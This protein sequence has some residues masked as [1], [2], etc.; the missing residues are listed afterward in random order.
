MIKQKSSKIVYINAWM[1]VRE[2]LVE[3]AGG[4]TGIFGVVEKPN[5]ALVI[6][7]EKNNFYLVQQYRYPVQGCY[8]EFP[9]GDIVTDDENSSKSAG[10]RELVEETGLVASSVRHLGHLFEAYGFC[11]QGFDIFLATDLKQGTRQLDTTEKGMKVESF[12]VKEF[13]QMIEKGEIKDGPTVS[14]YGL[15]KLK[16]I[17]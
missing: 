10:L 12:S 16:G 8:W 3:L 2:D 17:V 4:E 11:N 13:E 15:L 1:K 6:P 5:F 9:Q 7:Y 14:A